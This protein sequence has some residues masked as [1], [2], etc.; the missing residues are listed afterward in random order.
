MSIYLQDDMNT[1][2][3]KTAGLKFSNKKTSDFEFKV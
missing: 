1:I 2:H 3:W